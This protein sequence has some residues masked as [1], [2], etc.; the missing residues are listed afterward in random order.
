MRIKAFLA[1]RPQLA[2]CLI[3]AVMLL[4]AVGRW[5]Y[6]YYRLLRWVVCAAAVYVAWWGWST[7][8]PWMAW[9]WAVIAV[10]FNPVFPIH[11][12][13]QIWQ[14]LNVAG[15]ILFA[16]AAFLSGDDEG[17]DLTSEA[18]DGNESEGD[19][20]VPNQNPEQR[21]KTEGACDD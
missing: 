7:K 20:V 10:T 11:L 18:K 17:E 3:A 19:G 13:R 5:P 21:T 4:L 9:V 1:A 6:D 8:R 2:P 14:V 12:T 15:A 16:G